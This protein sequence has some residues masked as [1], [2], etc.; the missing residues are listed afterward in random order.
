MIPVDSEPF[1]VFV[2]EARTSPQ[3]PPIPPPKED[4]KAFSV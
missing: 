3:Y 2:P 1:D 4:K